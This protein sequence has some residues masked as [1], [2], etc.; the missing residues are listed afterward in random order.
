MNDRPALTSVP[1]PAGPRP[2]DDAD[3]ARRAID[4][5]ARRLGRS[6]LAPALL[7]LLESFRPL[8]FL[9]GQVAIGLTPFLSLMVSRA[10]LDA[11]TGLLSDRDRTSRFMDRLSEEAGR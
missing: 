8:L 1:E 3:A 6:G 5:L 11:L 4:D 10:H 7:L 9:G 2:A